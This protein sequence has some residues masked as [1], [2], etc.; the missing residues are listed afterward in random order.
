MFIIYYFIFINFKLLST[1]FYFI[2]IIYIDSYKLKI[3]NNNGKIE[4]RL[5]IKKQRRRN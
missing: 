4:I 3:Y 1:Y 5:D 2:Y